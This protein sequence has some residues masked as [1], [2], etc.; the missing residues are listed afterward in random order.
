MVRNGSAV[1]RIMR[2]SYRDRVEAKLRE[3]GRPVTQL[4]HTL[5]DAIETIGKQGFTLAE[6]DHHLQR[7]NNAR[8]RTQIWRTVALLVELECLYMV[9]GQVPRYLPAIHESDAI[10]VGKRK[11]QEFPT[12]EEAFQHA[13][14]TP[15]TVLMSI[16]RDAN[17]GGGR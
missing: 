15:R 1:L 11:L 7:T 5:L 12:K 3:S 8:H 16:A 13:K 4:R 14:T 6:L 9:P 17:E 10:Y 2:R